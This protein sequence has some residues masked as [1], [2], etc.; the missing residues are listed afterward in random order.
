MCLWIEQ[1]NIL[2]SQSRPMKPVR[3]VHSPEMWS[4]SPPFLHWQTWEQ[5]FPKKPSGQPAEGDM[6]YII[7]STFKTICIE[8]KQQTVYNVSHKEDFSKKQQVLNLYISC[9]TTTKT[10]HS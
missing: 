3:Q 5:S 4:Q 8:N 9:N 1:S 6:H 7:W 2:C 10:F